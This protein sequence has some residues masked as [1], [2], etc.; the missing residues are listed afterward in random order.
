MKH[1]RNKGIVFLIFVVLLG[2]RARRV[3]LTTVTP[4]PVATRQLEPAV[5]VNASVLKKLHLPE[6]N[7]VFVEANS[8]RIEVRVYKYFR[9]AR[10]CGLHRKELTELGLSYGKAK[11]FVQDAGKK[12]TLPPDP[13]RRKICF[14][15]GDTARWPGMVLAAPHADCD[16]ETGAV[17]QLVNRSQKIPCVSAWKHRLS[18]RGI[19]YDVNR[20]LMK[21]PRPNGHGVEPERVVNDSS[22]AV[23]ERYKRQVYRALE[24]PLN[25]PIP[26]YFDLH[27]HDLTVRLP[28]GKRIYRSVVE[29]VGTGFTLNELRRLKAVY[30]RFCRNYCDGNFPSLYIGN[31]PEDQNYRYKGVP[32]HIFYT[33][34][35]TRTYGI[36]QNDLV[37]RGF[38]METPDTLRLSP[39][40]RRKTARLLVTLFTFVRDSLPNRRFSRL[41][42][43]PEKIR[44]ATQTFVKIKGGE[45]VMGAPDG[46]G[47]ACSHPRHR[48][49]I[50]NFSLQATEVTNRAY[51]HFL[52][53]ALKGEKILVKNGVVVD[54]E[55]PF[56][57]LCRLSSNRPYSQIRWD[58]KSFSPVTGR[59]NFP[60]IYVSWYGA[61]AFAKH[62]G[63]RL[64]TE[65]EWEYAAG[66]ARK[67]PFLFGY[68]SN[69]YR[70][71]RENCENSGDVFERGFYPWTTPA[72]FYRPNARGL[73]DLSGNVW[74]WCADYFDYYYYRHE[75]AKGWVNPVGPDSGTMRSIRGGAWNTE[76]PFT[77]TYFRLGVDP[78]ATLINLGF[79]CAK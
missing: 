51:A 22:R 7:P 76:F 72:G 28:N 20:P 67:H 79:R 57:V 37:I 12:A 23:F 63:W 66:S 26:F 58:G 33:A 61:Q 77:A 46:M 11:V 73:Y 53:E 47:W 10:S 52:N 2:C 43:V 59:E 39:E 40:M 4:P 64:P 48:V 49:Q 29:A 1:I 38:H 42:F 69:T 19:W 75:P 71:V 62:F 31:L 50:G 45:F 6:G 15:K 8:R 68:D 41:N 32:V 17:V 44:P 3:P 21:L 13:I 18:Y 60:V 36:L 34:L 55:K 54:A 70:A 27:G 78:N 24:R 65:S 35:G 30:N 16:N 74:E 25:S 56:H 9:D 14:C 5:F